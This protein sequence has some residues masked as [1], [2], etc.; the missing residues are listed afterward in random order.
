MRGHKN[1]E[2]IHH[3]W[4]SRNIWFVNLDQSDVGWLDILVYKQYIDK[5]ENRIN[6]LYIN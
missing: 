1:F 2:P 4:C 3:P 6:R 5:G